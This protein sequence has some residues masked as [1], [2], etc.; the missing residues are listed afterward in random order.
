MHR[1]LLQDW[2]P[3]RF[4]ATTSRCVHGNAWSNYVALILPLNRS[5]QPKT[6]PTPGGAAKCQAPN[7][8]DAEKKKKTYV[9]RPISVGTELLA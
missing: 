1:L 3:M 9:Y 6:L 5:T 7:D 8:D 2:Q 4:R